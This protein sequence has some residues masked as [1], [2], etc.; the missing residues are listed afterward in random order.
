ASA[1]AGVQITAVAPKPVFYTIVTAK[2]THFTEA[3]T[4]GNKEDENLTGLLGSKIRILDI[5]IQADQKLNFWLMFWRKDTFNN[6]NLDVDA[7]IGMVQLDLATFGKQ[8][9][10]AGQYYMSLE[11]ANLDY[12]DEDGTNELHVSLYNADAVAK[13]AGATG[14][15]SV[16]LKHELRG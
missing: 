7:F 16:F 12:E 13:N 3:L 8:V 11:D 6:I 14:E 5:A 15:I 1:E 2:D 4:T 10:G 9:G